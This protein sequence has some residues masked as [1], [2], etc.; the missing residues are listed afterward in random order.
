[1]YVYIYI[2][3]TIP[4][5]TMWMFTA[6]KNAEFLIVEDPSTA[7]RKSQVPPLGIPLS[8]DNYPSL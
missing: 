5:Y 4:D 2:S 1:M 8:V 7:L 3:Y 6:K